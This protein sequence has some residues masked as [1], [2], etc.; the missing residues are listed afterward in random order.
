MNSIVS[1][2][3]DLSTKLKTILARAIPNGPFML[4]LYFLWATCLIPW[5][6][7]S[8]GENGLTGLTGSTHFTRAWATRPCGNQG[9]AVGQSGLAHAHLIRPVGADR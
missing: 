9:W 1:A 5:A 8:G 7:N 2:Q 4:S 6:H 3:P